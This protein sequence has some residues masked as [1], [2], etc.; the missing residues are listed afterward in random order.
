MKC[1]CSLIMDV[2]TYMHFL[3]IQKAS[4]NNNFVLV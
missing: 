2:F 1:C 4:V 3:E